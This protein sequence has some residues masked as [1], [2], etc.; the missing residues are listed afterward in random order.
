MTNNLNE[1]DKFLN[2]DINSLT[3]INITV[4]DDFNQIKGNYL[5]LNDNQ[6]LIKNTSVDYMIY[7]NKSYYEQQKE[8]IFMGILEIIKNY[9]NEEITLSSSLLITEEVLNEISK[10]KYIKRVNLG[11]VNDRYL[12]TSFDFKILNNN[13]T[14]EKIYTYGIEEE[15]YGIDDER[16][17]FTSS[18][19][20]FLN[21]TYSELIKAKLIFIDSYV[22]EEQ[23]CNI[24]YIQKDCDIIIDYKLCKN[25]DNIVDI[26]INLGYKVTLTNFELKDKYKNS[27]YFGK[28]FIET[29]IETV[30]LIDYIRVDNI[31][32][33]SL[34]DIKNSKL[35]PLEKYICAYNITKKFK[36]YKMLP[37]QIEND[38]PS[39]SRS[40]Y[41]TFFNEYLVCSGYMYMLKILCTKLGFNVKEVS[42]NNIYDSEESHSIIAVAI[43]DSKYG[44]NGIFYSDPTWDNDLHNDLYN[45]VLMSPYERNL[46]ENDYN[47]QYKL[48]ESNSEVEFANEFLTNPNSIIDLIELLKNL[49]EK[50]ITYLKNKY[51]L[52]EEINIEEIYINRELIYEL[53]NY[54]KNN[55][56]EIDINTLI[57]A[58]SEVKKFIYYNLTEEE[59]NKE[60]EETILLNSIRHDELLPNVKNKFK[61]F[62]NG[63]NIKSN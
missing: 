32:E 2:F 12:L 46:M 21:Y 19:E 4:V 28:V 17:G 61:E 16:I 26:L 27:K 22:D 29:D 59:L 37:E 36:E 53:Y 42:C 43:N 47:T 55:N 50:F 7:I 51:Q 52:G 38:N 9:K 1:Y 34:T 62:M 60:M 20:I 54:I 25:V 40:P 8:I 33:T 15:L 5:V 30:D 6:V 14:I 39:L 44:I 31:L 41:K 48:L 13:S 18:E 57:M 49:D 24:K 45:F 63:R 56:K 10:N 11:S 3:N 23:I 58:I 35:S